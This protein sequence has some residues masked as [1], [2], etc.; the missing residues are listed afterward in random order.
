MSWPPVPCHPPSSDVSRR[1]LHSSTGR[2]P[3]MN[4]TT[5]WVKRL[6]VTD[7]RRYYKCPLTAQFTTRYPQRPTCCVDRPSL[8]SAT[9]VFYWRTT[10]MT[11]QAM[12][13]WCRTNALPTSTAWRLR[14]EFGHMLIWWRQARC[15]TNVHVISCV[16]D[17]HHHHHHFICL[18]EQK[19]HSNKLEHQGKICT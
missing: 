1:P 16:T 18:K 15:F 19:K 3:Q 4:G 13:C 14:M 5:V 6:Q 10:P 12:A 7:G 8:A 17:H 2:R 9:P 11:W